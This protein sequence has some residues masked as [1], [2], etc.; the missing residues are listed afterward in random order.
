MEISWLLGLLSGA[1]G[2]WL[3]STLR[4]RSEMA[5]FLG[6]Q[7][8]KE[9]AAIAERA[10]RYQSLLLLS[11]ADLQDRLWHLTQKQA[12]SS[13]P[14]L[15]AEDCQAPAYA[16][17]PMTGEHYLVST[18]YL[19]AKYFAAVEMLRHE[20]RFLTY[21]QD[22]KTRA[23]RSCI[24]NVERAFAET[25]LQK[26]ANPRPKSDRPLFQLQQVFIGQSAWVQGANGLAWIDY[27]SFLKNYN[28]GLHMREDFV[29][30]ADLLRGSV[31]KVE[32]SFHRDRLKLVTNA[33]VD[34]VDQI[35]PPG[36]DGEGRY[37]GKTDRSKVNAPGFKAASDPAA[38]PA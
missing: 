5:I 29:A 7:G 35:D 24:K 27:P 14:V 17:W 28:D 34:L 11:A 38:S 9:D 37:V 20:L 23:V 31:G 6:Q 32:R 13:S 12:K 16:S 26:L 15:L 10:E 22:S 30:L 2:G 36:R 3:T 4:V 25:D 33:L 18:L 1:V 19:T 21:K 8:H